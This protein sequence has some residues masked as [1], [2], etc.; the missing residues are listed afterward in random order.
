MHACMDST[1]YTNHIGI[2][3]VSWK[4]LKRFRVTNIVPALLHCKRIE[5]SFSRL[6]VFASW[7]NQNLYKTIIFFLFFFCF[8]Q[9]AVAIAIWLVCHLCELR[10]RKKNSNHR[11]FNVKFTFFFSNSHTNTEPVHSIFA[12]QRIYN[13]PNAIE[14][15]SKRSSTA[16]ERYYFGVII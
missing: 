12:A 16:I 13:Q 9:C 3:F 10:R 8:A 15:K 1:T 2:A 7:N 4:K 14:V 5:T 6:C 11:V